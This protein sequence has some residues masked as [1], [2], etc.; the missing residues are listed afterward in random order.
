MMATLPPDA[1]RR[2]VGV[3]GMLGSDAAGERA[4]AALLANRLVKDHGLQWSDLIGA[5]P[6]SPRQAGPGP[7]PDGAADLALC[8]RHLGVVTAWESNFLQS[9]QRRR[10]SFKQMEILRGIASDLRRRGFA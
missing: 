8:L 2:L 7:T 4:A 1:L 5:A 6:A 3:L 9:I 10:R